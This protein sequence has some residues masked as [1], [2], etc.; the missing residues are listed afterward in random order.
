MKLKMTYTFLV[1]SGLVVLSCR[2]SGEAHTE[3]FLGKSN[4]ETLKQLRKTSDSVKNDSVT[5]DET[6]PPKDPPKT[7]THWRN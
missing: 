3:D 5:N 1:F 6:D 4:T 7:G 2:E